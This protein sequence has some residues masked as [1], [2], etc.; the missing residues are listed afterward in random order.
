[1]HYE[2]LRVVEVEW[3]SFACR[4]ISNDNDGYWPSCMLCVTLLVGRLFI[5]IRLYI[6]NAAVRNFSALSVMKN[7]MTSSRRALFIDF[8]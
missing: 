3:G 7:K 6:T 8:W 2:T 5:R 4:T 1:V